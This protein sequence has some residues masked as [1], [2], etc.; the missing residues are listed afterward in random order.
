MRKIASTLELSHDDW[1]KLRKTGIGGSDAG[2]ISGLNPY[3]SP[4]HVYLEKTSEY[5]E[6]EDNEAMRQGRDL[7]EYVARRFVEETGKRVMRRN[8]MFGS[9]EPGYEFM[10]ANIDRMVVGENAGLE[11]K[12]AST[13]SANNWKEGKIP[14]HY[15]CQ[16]YHY[17]AVTGADAWYLA[18]VVLGK[19]F[20]YFKVERDEGVINNLKAI[21]YRF[22]HENVLALNPPDPDGSDA[23]EEYFR[24]RYKDSD[25]GK[26]VV[27]GSE[28]SEKLKRYE[29]ISELMKKLDQEKKK[30]E[31]ETKAYMDT[32]E[33]GVADGYLVSWKSYESE[34]LDTKMLKAEKP[35]I[36]KDY[37]KTTSSRR[38]TVRVA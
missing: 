13:F 10:Y 23:T 35:E 3:V 36:Y 37:A 2:A 24:Q 6:D 11:C 38:F 31:E 4:M 8:C 26:S 25:P 22:W 27:L 5:F 32:A 12:T 29:E 17:M 34:R 19:D 7:E 21:E 9:D 1:L 33:V 30:I 15:L 14:P 18:V 20:R 28:Y 16:C